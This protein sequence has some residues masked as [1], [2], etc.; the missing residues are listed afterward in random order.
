MRRDIV[1]WL[2]ANRSGLDFMSGPW[3]RCFRIEAFGIWVSCDGKHYVSCSQQIIRFSRWDAWLIRR[4]YAK[5]W[6][7]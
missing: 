3:G 4:A 2:R 5:W 7:R 6:K 1:K